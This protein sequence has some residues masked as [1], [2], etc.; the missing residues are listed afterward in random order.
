[1]PRRRLWM[2]K[3]ALT[4]VS[5]L[6]SLGVLE[7]GTRRFGDIQTSTGIVHLNGQP[8]VWARSSYL[9][10]TL[11]KGVTYRAET[12]EF[13]VLYTMN[14]LGYRGDSPR[15][16]SKPSHMKRILIIGDS[17]T[18]GWGNSL[19]DTFVQKIQD[20]LDPDQ[21][22]V[23]NAGFHGGHSPD[24]YYAY[25]VQE[26]SLLE[27]N[28]VIVV[29]YGGNDIRDMT[30]NIW[31]ETDERGAPTKLMTIQ[32]YNDYKGE[33]IHSPQTLRK[34]LP[35][36]YRVPILNNSHAFVGITG[37]INR[38]LKVPD[39]KARLK[40]ETLTD[41]E[42]WRRFD[43]AIESIA[44]WSREHGVNLLFVTIPPVGNPHA[45][46]TGIINHRIGKRY[47]LP[48]IVAGPHL[49]KRAHYPVDRHFNELG[50]TILAGLI[51]EF[52]IDHRLVTPVR[53]E[54]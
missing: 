22:S 17:F 9:P 26:G 11:P 33:L 19:Q 43:I 34:F 35:W 16:I 31:L 13:D 40:R 4:T 42:V 41:D 44:A 32:L 50:N 18:L 39:V 10:F 7:L 12:P 46:T 51:M 25:L 54:P 27:P 6:F 5:I 30:E 24:S 23:I 49:S 52:L 48:L 15:S 47:A 36:N 8:G 28:I 45:D 14:K 1:M 21:Y 2:N 38:T 20:S 37:L 53:T 29:L 3:W